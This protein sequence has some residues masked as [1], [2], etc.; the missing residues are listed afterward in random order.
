[1]MAQ[2]QTMLWITPFPEKES[3][4]VEFSALGWYSK[5]LINT[6][7]T[8]YK[9]Q[10]IILAQEAQSSPKHYL[11]NQTKIQHLWQRGNILSFFRLLNYSLKL[12]P[13]T[14]HIQ[15]E[16]FCYG[17]I[18]STAYISFLIL[19]FRL[20][21]IKVVTTIHG[22]IPLSLLDKQFL[23]NN[24]IS[25]PKQIVKLVLFLLYFPVLN[26]SNNIIVHNRSLKDYL[27]NDY[28]AKQDRVLVHPLPQSAQTKAQKVSSFFKAKDQNKLLFFGH[29]ARY[30]G[31]D[32]LIE[33]F[34]HIK[35]RNWRLLIIGSIPKRYRENKE[36]RQWLSNIKNKALKYANVFW[37]EEYVKDSNIN[38]LFQSADLVLIPYPKNI[39]SSGPLSL[40]VAN[41]KP[42][43]TSQ[44]YER[45]VAKPL[46]YGKNAKDLGQAI[47]KY[48]SDK[49]LKSAVIKEV[50]KL[51][52]EWSNKNIAATL[53]ESYET[54]R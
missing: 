42:F 41:N 54:N 13:K 35:L 40:A 26:L 38:G 37:K 34:K 9:K 2:L 51:K 28:H 12:K 22:V 20:N 17:N 52:K 15:H 21:G 50:S 30:K 47:T 31:L 43:L 19:V 32:T 39:S 36:Y 1:M 18:L 49:E 45:V 27:V 24:G 53:I 11:Y 33:S 6:L 44:A 10:T 7:P 16:M 46:I 48:F 23:K 8:N 29:L 25:Y 4:S 5:N 3:D 14:I